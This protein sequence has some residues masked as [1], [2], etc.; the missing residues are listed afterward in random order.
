MF[1]YIFIIFV[2]HCLH[3]ICER[4]YHSIC[5]PLTL[6]SFIVSLY[7]NEHVVCDKIVNISMFLN[8]IKHN[9]YIHIFAISY[10][11]IENLSTKFDI[12]LKTIIK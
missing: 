8:T 1:K 3:F 5:F 7:S 12:K 11:L 6:K 10:A 9:T 4:I 2:T